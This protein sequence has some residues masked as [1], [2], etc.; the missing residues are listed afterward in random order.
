MASGQTY[1]YSDA[2]LQLDSRVKFADGTILSYEEA[3][4]TRPE[5]NEPWTGDQPPYDDVI[6][7][8]P[9]ERYHDVE[10]RELL[11]FSALA[12]AFVGIAAVAV[13]RRRPR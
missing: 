7:Y 2:N 12:L 5:M 13:V 3:F 9:G 1:Y 10:R 8:I 6:L 4:A 11:A